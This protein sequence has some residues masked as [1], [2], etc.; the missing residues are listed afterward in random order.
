MRF[1]PSQ[2][3][4]YR[5]GNRKLFVGSINC[6]HNYVIGQKYGSSTCPIDRRKYGYHVDHSVWCSTH[7]A[8]RTALTVLLPDDNVFTSLYTLPEHTLLI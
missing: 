2:A 5:R 6:A 1:I 7:F 8:E 4:T 3:R